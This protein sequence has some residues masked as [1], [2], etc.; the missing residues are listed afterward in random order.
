MVPPEQDIDVRE[1]DH[2]QIAV[3]NVDDDVHDTVISSHMEM[4]VLATDSDVVFEKEQ[5]IEVPGLSLTIWDSQFRS[6]AAYVTK[7][8]EGMTWLC[9]LSSADTMARNIHTGS[10]ELDG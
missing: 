4:P 7:F 3:A 9:L 6:D 8:C 10:R 5:M 1:I 2:A